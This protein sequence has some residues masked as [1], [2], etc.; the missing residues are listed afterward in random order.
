MNNHLIKAYL[1][2]LFLSLIVS[3][4]ITE[5]EYLID[6]KEFA[7]NLEGREIHT[8]YWQS[9]L[10]INSTYYTTNGIYYLTCYDPKID[11]SVRVMVY[12]PSVSYKITYRYNK[13]IYNVEGAIYLLVYREQYFYR[14]FINDKLKRPFWLP[15]RKYQI[16]IDSIE[17]ITIL[18][19][20]PKYR[21]K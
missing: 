15:K 8:Y 11:D 7:K 3:S 2:I 20:R 18:S 6:K 1:L 5:F 16:H 10:I 13:K 14:G 4:C 19:P 17:T 12:D 21:K 9:P